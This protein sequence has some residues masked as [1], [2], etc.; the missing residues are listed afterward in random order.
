[1]SNLNKE[2][3]L[4]TFI[5]KKKI[6][7]NTIDTKRLFF[8][9][10]KAIRN[11]ITKTFEKIKNYEMIMHCSEMVNS[12][13]W[14]ILRYTNNLKL[15]MFLCERAIVLF[16]E[17]ISLSNNL[18]SQDDLNILDVKLFIYKK[19][20]GPIK[21]GSNNNLNNEVLSVKNISKFIKDIMYKVF[22]LN[23]ENITSEDLEN[24]LENVCCLFSNTMHKIN[25]LEKINHI[26]N[27]FYLDEYTTINNIYTRINILKYKLEIYYYIISNSKFTEDNHIDIFND[28]ILKIPVL[29][30]KL[31]NTDIKFIENKNFTNIINSI[32]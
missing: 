6:V 14:I 16:I 5:E 25:L 9:Y 24:I 31:L 21:L 1:M 22:Y 11:S 30:N 28:T 18:S 17:Y 19:T 4:L 2:D 7:D 29:D 15:T 13:F 27:L 12:I 10:T 26:E 3:Q 8:I 32:K 20:I 23:Y